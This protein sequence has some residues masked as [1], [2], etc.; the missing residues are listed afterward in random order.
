MNRLTSK[1]KPKSSAALAAAA[2]KSSARRTAAGAVDP[3][4]S[5]G[6]QPKRRAQA[7]RCLGAAENLGEKWWKTMEIWENVRKI[8]EN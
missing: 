5:R 8:M 7:D 4:V 1:A 3:G 2:P 6:A